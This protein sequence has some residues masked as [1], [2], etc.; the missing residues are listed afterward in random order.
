MARFVRKFDI[1]IREL[2]FSFF[3]SLPTKY[4]KPTLSR[5]NG[6]GIT[7]EMQ[8]PSSSDERVEYVDDAK[9]L[10]PAELINSLSDDGVA[11]KFI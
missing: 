10:T 11:V 8:K 9:G 1:I 6:I 4:G 7:Q 2:I 5:Q 3:L